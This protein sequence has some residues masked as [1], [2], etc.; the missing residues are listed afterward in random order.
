[1]KKKISLFILIPVFLRC[2]VWLVP[3]VRDAYGYAFI[4]QSLARGLVPYRDV[5][6]HK[7]P[8][9]YF[10]NAIIFFIA[11]DYIFGLRIVSIVCSILSVYIFY[12]LLKQF[13]SEKISFITSIL[14]ALFSNV[15]VITQGDNLVEVYMLPLLVFSYY[16]FYFAS[17]T[18]KLSLYYSCGILVGLLFLFKQVGVLPLGAMILYLLLKRERLFKSLLTIS[19]GIATPLIPTVLYFLTQNA[20]KDAWYA[21]FLYNLSYAGEG[22]SIQ[23][24]SQSLYYV[25]QV[26]FATFLYWFLGLNGVLRKKWKN[27][28]VLF[29]FFLTFSILGTALGGKFAFTRNYFLLVLP[30]FGYFVAKGVED[31]YQMQKKQYFLICV[32]FL[33][34]S[35][36]FQSQAI[37]TGFYYHNFF[38]PGEKEAMYTLG[39]TNYNFIK[40]AVTFKKIAL[41]L[42]THTTKGDFILDWGAEPEV[43]LLPNLYSP[44]RFWYNF[45]IN[46]A[47]IKNNT[48]LNSQRNEFMKQI[49]ER[50]PLYVITNRDEQRYQYAFDKLEFPDFKNFVFKNYSLDTTI[51]NYLL[52]KRIHAYNAI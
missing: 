47:F 11:P 19:I 45:P 6:D 48:L 50:N 52:F 36:I 25:I 31:L 2:S 46:G 51:D 13:Y 1:M 8:G 18:K 49:Q 44:T 12:K 38:N 21:I 5:W 23:S 37:L 30:A 41:Y 26:L 17:K 16:I 3:F 14:F 35:L 32:F 42:K 40:D 20:G 10:A 29:L 33:L 9:I 43:Y 34:S 15:Y 4:G 28:D 39:L 22:Y 7:P 24:V 27:E